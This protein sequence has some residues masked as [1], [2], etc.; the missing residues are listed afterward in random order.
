M[1]I[2]YYLFF[3]WVI[4]FLL[5]RD[6]TNNIFN[7]QFYSSYDYIFLTVITSTLFSCSSCII[8]NME[9]TELDNKMKPNPEPGFPVVNPIHLSL[10]SF[11]LF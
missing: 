7:F 3:S 10:V 9:D 8:S 11:H 4:F 5:N 2:F 6:H 1:S